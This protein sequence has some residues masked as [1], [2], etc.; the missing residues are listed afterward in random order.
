[1]TVQLG[2]F[3]EGISTVRFERLSIIV[4]IVGDVYGLVDV[5]RLF[6][7][8]DYNF[9]SVGSVLNFTLRLS[10][11]RTFHRGL[12]RLMCFNFC[13]FFTCLRQWHFKRINT[14]CG[15]YKILSLRDRWSGNMKLPLGIEPV[16]LQYKTATLDHTLRR[17]IRVSLLIRRLRV[18]LSI[19][20]H[21][22]SSFFLSATD[23]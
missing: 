8:N 16:K 6:I 10:V 2:C 1:M 18:L 5:C 11:G 14:I 12:F 19:R 13:F 9:G 23:C 4:V 21:F 3:N 17:R 20:Y 7:L 15:S 22:Q